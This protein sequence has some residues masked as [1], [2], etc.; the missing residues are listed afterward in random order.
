MIIVLIRSGLTELEKKFP[1]LL[2]R[3]R[4]RGT[5]C[6]VDLPDVA[7]RYIYGDDNMVDMVDMD[8]MDDMDD[9][10]MMMMTNF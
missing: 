4:G 1:A 6:A 10:S 8:D 7:A 9:M 2:S 3:A 5:F